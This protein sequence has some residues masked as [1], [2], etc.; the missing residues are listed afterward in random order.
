MLRENVNF[1]AFYD[2]EQFCGILYTAENDKYVFILYFAVNGEIR[3]KG[4]GSQI[5]QWLKSDTSK[6]IVL[7][8]EA[9]ETYAVNFLQ[10]EKRIAFYQRN[11]IT[12]TSYT[13]VDAEERYSV[14]S[15]DSERFNV[16][17]YDALLKWLSL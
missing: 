5:L 1:R 11:G 8:V 6:N 14:L 4:Y 9:I 7:N 12:D 10:R 15:S 2:R 13:F 3:S 16:Q 17:E